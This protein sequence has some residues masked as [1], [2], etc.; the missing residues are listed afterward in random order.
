M[1]RIILLL[2]ATVISAA[3]LSAEG[4][5]TET[6]ILYKSENDDYSA[7]MCRLDLAYEEGAKDRPVIVLSLIHISEP[8]RTMLIA[9]SVFGV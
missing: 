6:D 2:I 7:K 3:A 1:K 4:Y 8:T 5:R 9:Y